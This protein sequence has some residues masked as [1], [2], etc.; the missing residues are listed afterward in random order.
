MSKDIKLIKY[1]AE[2]CG[3]CRVM[4]P[5]LEGIAKENPNV[6][7]INEDVEQLDDLTLKNLNIRNIPV[8]ILKYKDEEL[9]RWAGVVKKEVIIEEL[10]KIPQQPKDVT[11][12]PA[13]YMY[14]FNYTNPSI[15]EVELTEEDWNAEDSVLLVDKYGFDES[16]CQWLISRT[17]LDIVK[18]EK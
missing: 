4:Q 17:K 15:I 5:V 18:L 9:T 1:G 3:M 16:S 2:H 6:E 10:N 7:F 12:E 11:T 14:V 8:T 13:G